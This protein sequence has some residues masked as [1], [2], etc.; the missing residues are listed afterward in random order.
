MAI[1]VATTI[2]QQ[3][4]GNRFLIM[5]GAKDL[6]GNDDSLTM[7]LPRNG[8]N[9][10]RVTVALV[11]GDEYRVTTYSGRGR[12]LAARYANVAGLRATFEDMTALRVSL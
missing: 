9:V 8:K 4:G 7:R 1:A 6:V 2:L 3:L 12:H 5:T 10:G 11:L